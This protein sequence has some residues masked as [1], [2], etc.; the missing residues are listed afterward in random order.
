MA[1]YRLVS[2]VKDDAPSSVTSDTQKN[3]TIKLEPG[4]DLSNPELKV[5]ALCDN[6][7]KNIVPNTGGSSAPDNATAYMQL[8][9]AFI[10]SG[11]IDPTAS[12]DKRCRIYIK[13]DT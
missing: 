4:S 6:I 1:N 12:I 10:G 8:F 13:Y 3:Q 7:V 11:T 9:N 2:D 5:F